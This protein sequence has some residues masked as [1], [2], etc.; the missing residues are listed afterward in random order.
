[1]ATNQ[2]D[3]ESVV[4]EVR[5]AAQPETIF[6]FF[7]DPEKMIR[8]KGTMADLDPRPGGRYHVNV[9]PENVASG[10][11]VEIDPPRRVVFTW[12]WEGSD[13]VPPGSSTVEIVLT[14]E[15]SK[16]LVTLT[17]SNLP[18]AAGAQHGEGWDH[19]LPRLAAA[20]SGNDP[21]I[22]PWIEQKG[23]GNG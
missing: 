1:M 23:Q 16:T 22:D 19:Y 4:C 21:G 18:A 15:G 6:A 10:E 2:Q 17:H 11:Y 9:T 14:P 7:V 13:A 5:I 12:G 8:W 20:A 3:L